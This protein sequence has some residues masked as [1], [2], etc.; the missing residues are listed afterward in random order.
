MR[1]I[2]LYSSFM[3]DLDLDRLGI[4]FFN[5]KGLETI[6]LNVTK[7]VNKKYFS[8]VSKNI[9]IENEI[10][11]NDYIHF[12]NEILN[13]TKGPYLIISFLHLNKNTY[14]LHPGN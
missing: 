8:K 7:I 11:I 12:K 5:A 13:F 6:I 9:N 14:K 4:N 2:I 3:K 10:F 1:I